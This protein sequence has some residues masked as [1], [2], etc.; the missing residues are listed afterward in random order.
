M[1][2]LDVI[3]ITALTAALF[4]ILLTILVLGQDYRSTLHRV[5]LLW[6]ASIAFWNFGVYHLSQE[7]KDCPYEDA[8]FW[9]KFCQLGVICIPVSIFHLAM[10]ISKTNIG[11]IL[12]ALYAMTGCFAISLFLNR[13]I[14]GV[15]WIDVGYFSIPGPGF[16]VFTVFYIAIITSFMV[17]LY[18]K[19]KVAPPTQRRRM[20]AL[21]LALVILWIFGTNDMMPI[22]NLKHYPFT[23]IEFY[24]LGSLAAIFYVVIISYS[25]MQH[26]LLDIHVTLSRLAAQLVRLFFMMLVGFLLLLLAWRLV[27]G[28]IS[29][30]L[31]WPW[32]CCWSAGWWRA[33]SFL[34]FLGTAAINWNGASWAI[35][36][37][38]TPGCKP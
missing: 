11:W 9:A 15:K 4:N 23:N 7:I 1:H 18:R 12:R 34:N 27:P 32:G 3:R 6:G 16:H 22:W 26:Q 20:R 8:F 10:I 5:Y 19:Q 38:I 13:F 17:I 21:L 30:I 36:L 35:S 28:Q 31:A 33:S 25:V 2:A 14:I 24:P 29:P 37:N